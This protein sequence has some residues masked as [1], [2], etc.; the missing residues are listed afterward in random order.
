MDTQSAELGLDEAVETF[1]RFEALLRSGDIEALDAELCAIEW[2][3]IDTALGVV[4][5]RQC[6]LVSDR[7]AG[8]ERVRSRFSGR[9]PPHRRDAIMRC[10]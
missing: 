10:L 9:L 6:R 1:R 2:E 5:L 3:Q 7:L 8:Y 4:V